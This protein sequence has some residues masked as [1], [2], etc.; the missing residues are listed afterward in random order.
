MRSG[1]HHVAVHDLSDPRVQRHLLR[2]QN[3]DVVL[4]DKACLLLDRLR[5]GLF[6]QLLA[7]QPEEDVLLT[8][9]AA[10]EVPEYLATARTPHQSVEALAPA[11]NFVK[12]GPE[13]GGISSWRCIL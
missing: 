2:G 11:S 10:Q 5:V 7:R 4:V 12:R 3:R 9:L 1:L 13:R 8:V 6:L